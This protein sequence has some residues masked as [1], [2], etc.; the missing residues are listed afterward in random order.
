MYITDPE[1]TD[2]ISVDRQ[3]STTKKADSDCDPELKILDKLYYKL[4]NVHIE[5]CTLH[6]FVTE[7]DITLTGN[8]DLGYFFYEF[9][10][11]EYI[12]YTIQV[13]LMDKVHV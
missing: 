8:R 6:E 13:I 3:S 9:T 2:C 5:E 1:A 7:N 12:P 4:Y 10:V 11:P